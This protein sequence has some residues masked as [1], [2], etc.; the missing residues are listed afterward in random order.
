M[1]GLGSANQH[2]TVRILTQC[3][4]LCTPQESQPSTNPERTRP[5]KRSP[6]SSTCEPEQLGDNL[7]CFARGPVSPLSSGVPHEAFAAEAC[8]SSISSQKNAKRCMRTYDVVQNLDPGPCTMAIT[9]DPESGILNYPAPT[10]YKMGTHA[11][12]PTQARVS[13][14]EL[15]AN[16]KSCDMSQGVCCGLVSVILPS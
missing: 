13:G 11:S 2:S 10:I 6:K 8:H 4:V 12:N 16:F 9:V 1:F 3:A 5:N 15:C 14:P 7:S